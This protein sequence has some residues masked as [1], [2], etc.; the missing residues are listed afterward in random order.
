[1]MLYLMGFFLLSGGLTAALLRMITIMMPIIIIIMMM[2][3]DELHGEDEQRGHGAPQSDTH[4]YRHLPIHKINICT[5]I[6]AALF[7]PA[8]H[9]TD[10]SGFGHRRK[11]L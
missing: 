11:I 1:M 10:A 2:I 3:P 6:T 5:I 8:A 9:C 7:A 4:H